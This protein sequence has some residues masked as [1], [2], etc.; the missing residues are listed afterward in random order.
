M[1]IELHIKIEPDFIPVNL[2]VETAQYLLALAGVKSREQ[3][4]KSN[5]EYDA[6]YGL[7]A[8]ERDSNRNDDTLE[9]KYREELDSAGL[10]WDYRIHSAN[11]T[12]TADGKWKM[13]RN[14]GEKLTHKVTEDN[15]IAMI[16][17]ASPEETTPA[18][19]LFPVFMKTATAQISAG[20]LNHLSL[21]KMLQAKGIPDIPSVKIRQDLIS[22]LIK[23][24][25]ML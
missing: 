19:D 13:K 12:K 8:D 14:V 2:C 11:K 10:P 16:A 9:T 22:V 20:K 17:P 18:V 6:T 4:E 1:T 15:R 25:E 24:I 23:E 3:T 7:V 5:Y 21:L